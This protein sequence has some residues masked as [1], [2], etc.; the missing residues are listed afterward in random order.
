MQA[1]DEREGCYVLDGQL[2]VDDAYLC[3]ER[4]AVARSVADRRTRSLLP[5]QLASRAH[6]A[7]FGSL[8]IIAN[9]EPLSLECLANRGRAWTTRIT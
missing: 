5:P 1:M 4:S 6:S 7:Q 9:Q 2:Q 8:R 3:G